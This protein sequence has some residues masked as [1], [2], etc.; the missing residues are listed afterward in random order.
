MPSGYS[1]DRD[2]RYGRAGFVAA[3]LTVLVMEFITWVFIV[4]WYMLPVT[5]V[6]ALV[7]A[8]LIGYCL[9]R[10]RG[11]VAQIGRGVLNGCIAAPLTVI[12][13]IPAWILVQAIGPV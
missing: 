13:F 11:I 2:A 9:T 12:I 3:L 7:V 6:P 5:V 10:A 4:Y 8:G 1:D